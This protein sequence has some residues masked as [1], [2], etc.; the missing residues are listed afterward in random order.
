MEKYME[1]TSRSSVKSRRCQIT[2]KTP[3]RIII[4]ELNGV[5][6]NICNWKAPNKAHEFGTNDLPISDQNHLNYFFSDPTRTPKFLT[7]I[8]QLSKYSPV[9]CL[10]IDEW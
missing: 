2:L 3:Q 7:K 6:I 5:L 1:E 10:P 9:I 8:V 4:Q